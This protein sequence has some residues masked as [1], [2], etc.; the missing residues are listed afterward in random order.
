MIKAFNDFISESLV[1]EVSN[2]VNEHCKKNVWGVSNLNY[3]PQLIESSA[4][5]FS[6]RLHESI[7]KKIKKTYTDK[8][9]EFKNKVFLIEYKIYAPLSYITWHGDDVY[10]AGSTIYLNRGYYKND[11]GLFLYKDKKNAIKGI[12]PKFRSM[13]LNYK[14][15]NEHCVSM[16]SPS[17]KFLRETLQVFVVE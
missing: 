5:I 2:Y 12:E 6:L 11:G 15:K 16:I 8:F 4:P 9:P 13:I 17:P 7:D 3:D 10:L 1:G 14:D